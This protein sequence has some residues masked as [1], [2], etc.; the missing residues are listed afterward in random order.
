MRETLDQPQS[1]LATLP[2]TPGQRRSAVAVAAIILIAFAFTI[3]FGTVQ[4]PHV[5]AI[6]PSLLG[7]FC[8]NDFLTAVLLYS[9][10]SIGRSPALLVLASGYLFAALIAIPWAL[11]FPGAFSPTGVLG[12][13]LQTTGWLYNFWHLI[14]SAAMLAFARLK[15][16]RPGSSIA[17]ISARRGIGG[18]VA[19]VVGLVLGI[20]WLTISREQQLPAL[21]LDVSH[22]TPLVFQLGLFSIFLN[23]IALSSLWVRR[24][25]VL[26]QWLMV[27]TLAL[28]SE[29][30]L[31]Q[32]FTTTRFSF[33]FYSGLIHTLAT[34]IVV[35]VVLITETTRLD[36]RLA[37]SNIMLQRERDNKLMSLAAMLASISHEVRQPL[38]AISMHGGAALR[39]LGRAPPDLG[40]VRSAL[41][42]MVNDSLRASQI[43]DSIGSLFK[44]SDQR[45][46]AVDINTV[47]LGVM[48]LLRRDLEEHDVIARTELSIGLPHIVGH[49]G[50]LQ[51]VLV[52]L[53]NNAIEAMDEI[54]DRTRTLL[55]KTERH[56][57]NEIALTVE[58]SGPGIEP[59]RL[60]GIFDAFVTSKFQGTGLGLAICQI[61]IERHGGQ[62]SARS[63]H[64]EGGALFRC[65][66]PIEPATKAVAASH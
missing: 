3:P 39:F 18:S 60:G 42:T 52:N 7:I 50:Q 34:S 37:R 43:F 24:R 16:I 6:V 61:I 9:Q 1:L 13:G 11:T 54:K 29:A 66:L 21:F 22:H 23:T 48:R 28:I 8:V 47:A 12:A 2:P 25:S 26:D 31:V 53:V 27:V 30:A 36:A 46:E 63:N 44:G 17:A 10:F 20:T 19:I 55:I 51:E 14:F 41:N 45:Q 4:L 15:D 32:L 57:R 35:L 38:M 5:G 59:E 49:R 64:N 33:G 65:I 40:E 58:D 56:G 62:I